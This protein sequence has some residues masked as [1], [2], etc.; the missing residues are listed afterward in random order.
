M[1]VSLTRADGLHLAP[2]AT[3][4]Q[5]LA[6][7][8]VC[9][10]AGGLLRQALENVEAKDFSV[11]A[12]LHHAGPEYQPLLAALLALDADVRAV[13]DDETRV[14]PLVGFFSYRCQLPPE[15]FPLSALRLP[16]LNPGGH[17]LLDQAPNGDWLVVRADIHPVLRVC[18]HMRLVAGQR[19]EVPR[20]L[21]VLEHRLERQVLTEALI[22]SALTAAGE[23]LSDPVRAKVKELLGT[24]LP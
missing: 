7:E 18:G 8:T 12:V 2:P 22:D 3:L 11:T 21:T 4:L 20:R 10:F 16:P 19:A 9:T 6:D 15:C 14:F 13:I 1:Q 24:L 5:L 17:Y 23:M